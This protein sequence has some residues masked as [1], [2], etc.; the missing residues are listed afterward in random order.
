ML[1]NFP[2]SHTDCAILDALEA[3]N[4]ALPAVRAARTVDRTS[5]AAETAE[6]A[7]AVCQDISKNHGR[8]PMI[9]VSLSDTIHIREFK[10]RHRHDSTYRQLK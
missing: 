1:V 6:C 7:K 3:A 8:I 10:K 4:F 9:V 5:S 2:F